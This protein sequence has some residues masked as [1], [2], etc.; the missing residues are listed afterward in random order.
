[1]RAMT[2]KIV[3]LVL[4]LLFLLCMAVQFNDPD[5]WFWVLLYGAV[6]AIAALAIF[7]RFYIPL[8]L[9]VLGASSGVSLYLMPSVLELF[10]QHDPSALV[11]RMSADKPYI[12]ESRE[13]LGSFFAALAL[14]YFY[15]LARRM[16]ALATS[17]DHPVDL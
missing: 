1:M 3:N 5:P 10:F 9:I 6:T 8:I 16:G 15:V 14:V 4:M 7:G 13:S 17:P 12:E 2:V 11:E